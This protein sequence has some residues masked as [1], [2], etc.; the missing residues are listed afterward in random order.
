MMGKKTVMNY[1]YLMIISG[2]TFVRNAVKY[3][4]PV[5]ESIRSILPI[6][7][8]FVVSV[9]D[10]DDGTLEL[11][12]SI[13]SPKI[14]IVHS[15]WDD[16]LRA[17]GQVLAV[18]TD[19]AFAHVRSDAD[20]AF[21]LQ[22]DE[23]VHEKYLDTIKSDAEKYLGNKSVEGLLFKYMHMYGSYDY[24]GDSRKWYAREVRIIRNDRAI[25]SWKDAQGFRKS[26]RKLHVK[27]IDAY[28]YHYGWVRHPKYQQ[29]KLQNVGIYWSE[30]QR[31]E[32][33]KQSD[34]LFDYLKH[35]DS[36]QKFTGTHPAVMK[37]RI[38]ENNWNIEFDLKKK[39]MS[40]N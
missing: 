8:E 36:L 11:I 33:R 21:Y 12:L 37:K 2:F 14:K 9:G 19:K 13:N 40:I 31:L 35:A 29:H 18:E 7:D 4:Y 22:A 20:W 15:I 26:E 32:F 1:L 16:S 23:V 10:S 3:D 28:I 5:T 17:G 38:D 25:H 30:D 6:V 39:N 24:V 34:E 27:L